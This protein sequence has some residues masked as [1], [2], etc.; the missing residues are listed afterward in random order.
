LAA[1]RVFPERE[2]GGGYTNRHKKKEH[3]KREQCELDSCLISLGA[4]VKE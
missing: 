2:E 3:G 4:L 1:K